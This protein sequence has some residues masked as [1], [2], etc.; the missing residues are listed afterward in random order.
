MIIYIFRNIQ[1]QPSYALMIIQA[2]NIKRVKRSGLGYSVKRLEN[3]TILRSQNIP[4]TLQLQ[5][6]LTYKKQAKHIRKR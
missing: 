3:S 4:N 5:Q 6:N 2:Q 1:S